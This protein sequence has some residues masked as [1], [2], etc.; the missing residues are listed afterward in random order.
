MPGHLFIGIRRASGS[1]MG[2]L[3][4]TF[5]IIFFAVNI[6]LRIMEILL[7]DENV[8]GGNQ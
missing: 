8:C 4:P 1:T 7:V 3:N 5:G 6:V 2:R